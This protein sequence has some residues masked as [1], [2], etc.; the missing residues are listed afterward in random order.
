MC[1]KMNIWKGCWSMELTLAYALGIGASIISIINFA[2]T[3]KDKAVQDS[4]ESNLSVITYRLDKLDENMQKILD[5]LDAYELE[6]DEKI[7]KAL[8]THIAIYH[9][10][11]KKGD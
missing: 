6:I 3:R 11:S 10:R 9:K 1:D 4:K 5:K 8:A 2:L 7:D